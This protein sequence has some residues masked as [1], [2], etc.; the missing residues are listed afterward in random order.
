MT[1]EMVARDLS[2]KLGLLSYDDSKLA[3]RKIIIKK[4]AC[5]SS[6]L[7]YGK[8]IFLDAAKNSTNFSRN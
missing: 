5:Y 8:W 6:S 2:Y 1:N 3:K 7:V 4:I